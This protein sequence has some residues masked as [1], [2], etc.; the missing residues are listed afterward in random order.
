MAE[1]A[2]SS[3]LATTRWIPWS[4]TR[5]PVALLCGVSAL[6]DVNPDAVDCPEGVAGALPVITEG[7]RICDPPS[8]TLTAAGLAAGAAAAVVDVDGVEAAFEAAPP[9]SAAYA[10]PGLAPGA[11][12]M[13][14]LAG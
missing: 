11:R 1:S 12:A 10:D 13:A 8:G 3:R 14:G 2:V 6:A 7:F 4:S 9:S 5:S